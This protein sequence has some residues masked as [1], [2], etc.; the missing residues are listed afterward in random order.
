[1]LQRTV[2]DPVAWDGFLMGNVVTK[3]RRAPQ[4]LPQCKLLYVE[5][6]PASIALVEQLLAGRPDVLLLRAADGVLGV[7]LARTARPEVILL[8]VDLPGISALQFMKLLRADPATQST[9]ILALSANGAADV[10]VKAI[11]AGFFQYLTTP[12]KAAPF[13]EALADALEFAAR[14]RAEENDMP[15]QRPLAAHSH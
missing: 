11:E 1:V 13:M 3:N 2:L 9:P 15:L 5:A 7:E 10:I 8:N 12:F 4:A 14:E 6:H